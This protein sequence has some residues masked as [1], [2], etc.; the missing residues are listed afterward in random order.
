MTIKTLK[1]KVRIEKGINRNL[2]NFQTEIHNIISNKK[3]WK[4]NFI[5]NQINFDF[6]IILAKARNITKYCS[7]NGL[8][9]VDIY[10]KKIYINNYRWVNGAKPSKLDIKN[11]R[12]YLIL[13]E[14]GHILGMKHEEPPKKKILTKVM[15]QQTLNIGNGIP[16]PWPQKEEQKKLKDINKLKIYNI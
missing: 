3:S 15:V 4:V 2:K 5:Q 1:Y 7:F 16:N 9:C 8:S 10:Y 13:H 11:Y 14:V 6:E 12:I